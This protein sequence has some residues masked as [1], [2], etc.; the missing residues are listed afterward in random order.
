MS[1]ASIMSAKSNNFDYQVVK[2]FI[3][4]YFLSVA[5][6]IVK[7][8]KQPIRFASV[9]PVNEVSLIHEL[10]VDNLLSA[11]SSVHDQ[12]REMKIN[13][14]DRCFLNNSVVMSTP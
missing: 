12:I 8:I 10:R 1:V 7:S 2:I 14:F 13:E 9:A 3:I 11:K 4:F 5:G 6:L